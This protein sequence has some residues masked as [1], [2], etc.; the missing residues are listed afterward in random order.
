MLV[1]LAFFS[2]TGKIMVQEPRPQIV[3]QLP[4]F[5]HDYTRI[6]RVFADTTFRLDL[7]VLSA[8]R[9]NTTRECPAAKLILPNTKFLVA[10]DAMYKSSQKN[11]ALCERA[12]SRINFLKWWLVGMTQ[13][14]IIFYMDLDIDTEQ[15]IAQQVVNAVDYFIVNARKSNGCVMLCDGDWASAVNTGIMMF[16]PSRPRYEQMLEMA[17]T[18]VFDGSPRNGTGFNRSGTPL[19]LVAAHSIFGRKIKHRVGQTGSLM[20]KRNSWNTIAGD[21]DQGLFSW[22]GLQDGMCWSGKLAVYHMWWTYKPYKCTRWVESANLTLREHS[23][24]VDV[25][26][27]WR[28]ESNTVC[29]KQR[30]FI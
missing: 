1:T 17:A 25:M 15:V 30:Q 4:S 22:W 24:C 14:D 23:I 8:T 19:S 29:R 5:C 26:R 13:Y 16:R 6:A 3:C 18:G 21:S 2:G 7:G 12:N 9:W 11:C 10:L 27:G 20:L 28:S